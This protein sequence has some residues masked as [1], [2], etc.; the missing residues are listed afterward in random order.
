MS[1]RLLK[2]RVNSGERSQMVIE[3]MAVDEIAQAANV[4]VKKGQ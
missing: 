1:S 3:A 2:I 4:E